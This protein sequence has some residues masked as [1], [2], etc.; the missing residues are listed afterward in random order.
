ME[1][2]IRR[3]SMKAA[4]TPMLVTLL[5]LAV[6]PARANPHLER[7]IRLVTQAENAKAI[8]ALRRALQARESPS[9]EQARIHLYLGIAQFNLLQLK[10]ARA[11]FRRALQLDPR[12][13]LPEGGSP[14]LTSFFAGLKPSA[15]P[16]EPTPTPAPTPPPAAP[17]PL[18]TVEA[19]APPPPAVAA[20]PQTDRAPASHGSRYWPAWVCL[21]ATVAAGAAG[22]GLGVAARRENNE[23]DNLKLTSQQADS[24][25]Q[26]ASRYATGANVLYG[27]TAAGAVGTAVLFYLG[28]RRGQRPPVSAAVSPSGAVLQVQAVLW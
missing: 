3:T 4:I 13:Q 27:I 24:H 18:P 14:K 17:T 22:I 8:H 15:P 21:A 2:T 26:S 1:L 19:P 28:W 25:S 11:S 7:G 12:I 5:L 23:V 10:P 20:A 9:G 6:A 16:P